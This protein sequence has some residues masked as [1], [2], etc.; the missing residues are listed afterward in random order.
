METC[1]PRLDGETSADTRVMSQG[2]RGIRGF[3]ILHNEAEMFL[4]FI[5]SLKLLLRF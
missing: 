3:W 5:R 4:G 1:T 2:D